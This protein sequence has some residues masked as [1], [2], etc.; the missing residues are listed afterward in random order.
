MDVSQSSIRTPQNGCPLCKLAVIFLKK[1][2]IAFLTFASCKWEKS[3]EVLVDNMQMRKVRFEVD[4][5]K[6][7]ALIITILKPTSFY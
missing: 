3:A 7:N 1:K 2:E 5:P 4:T 6:Q